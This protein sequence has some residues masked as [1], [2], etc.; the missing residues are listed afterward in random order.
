MF[1]FTQLARSIKSMTNEERK[2]HL[3][4]SGTIEAIPLA[5]SNDSLQA[6]ARV[7]EQ[8]LSALHSELNYA[9]ASRRLRKRCDL[10]P[11]V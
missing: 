7:V 1:Y 11:F 3:A 8:K 10:V 9:I 6:K 2:R 4:K 5:W